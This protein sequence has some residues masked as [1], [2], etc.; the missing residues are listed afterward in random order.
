MFG[1]FA[2]LLWIGAVLCFIAHGIT[3]ATHHE[4]APNDNVRKKKSNNSFYFI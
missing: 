2:F 4:D 3:V 1:G